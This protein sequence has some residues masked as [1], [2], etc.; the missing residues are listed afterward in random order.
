MEDDVDFLYADLEAECSFR[1]QRAAAQTCPSCGAR[2]AIPAVWAGP[3]PE[4]VR[5]KLDELYGRGG[6]VLLSCMSDFWFAYGCKN[7]GH[8]WGKD[9]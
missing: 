9:P 1:K 2:Q 7:C 6:H 4:D 8:G 3:C 5:R